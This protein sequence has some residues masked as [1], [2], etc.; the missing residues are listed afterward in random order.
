MRLQETKYSLFIA[1]RLLYSTSQG[2]LFNRKSPPIFGT[3][4]TPSS[5]RFT[6]CMTSA[7]VI[8]SRV[9]RDGSSS[10]IY[11]YPKFA[12][13][14]SGWIRRHI[15]FATIDA[16][17]NFFFLFKWSILPRRSLIWARLSPFEF[18]LSLKLVDQV[19]WGGEL[20]LGFSYKTKNS[21]SR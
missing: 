21:S 2:R 9:K 20:V 7:W 10:P 17:V 16:P 15:Q 1:N 4:V 19:F 5:T 18:Q 3:S 8:L 6:R 11:M 12:H 13:C 14:W